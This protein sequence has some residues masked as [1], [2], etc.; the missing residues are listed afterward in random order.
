MKP[1]ILLCCALWG[2]GDWLHAEENW[3]PLKKLDPH[4]PF[5][6]RTP[7]EARYVVQWHGLNAGES[8]HRLTR[9]PRGA[10]SMSAHTEPYVRLLPYRYH[11]E[12]AFVFHPDGIKPVA[13]HYE[14][15]EGGEH[16][17]GGWLFDWQSGAVLAQPPESWQ[18]SL[19]QPL[20]DKLTHTLKIRQ[21]LNNGLTELRYPVVD[22]GHI[23]EYVFRK[24][25][26]E[27]LDTPLGTLNTVLLEHLSKNRRSVFWLAKDHEFFLVRLAQYRNKKLVGGGHLLSIRVPEKPALSPHL[28]QT[29]RASALKGFQDF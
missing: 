29:E 27:S 25:G 4:T 2:V 18:L 7:Y 22:E 15:Q 6:L 11:E 9:R 17:Q 5:T 24:I 21:D 28:K 14:R 23:T 3:V 1:I 19:D 20:F 13:Y 26:E 10:F 8:V 12:A 16:T